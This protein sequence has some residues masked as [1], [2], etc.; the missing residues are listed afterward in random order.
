MTIFKAS[1]TPPGATPL[2]R[3]ISA[4][5]WLAEEALMLRSRNR[6]SALSSPIPMRRAKSPSGDRSA[7]G[8]GGSP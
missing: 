8:Y 3:A 6:A 2:S 4:R 1:N 5:V 7:W